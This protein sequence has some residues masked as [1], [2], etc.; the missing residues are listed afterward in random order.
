MGSPRYSTSFLIHISTDAWLT[1]LA[2]LRMKALLMPPPV[3]IS[4]SEDFLVRSILTLMYIYAFVRS[5]ILSECYVQATLPFL[6]LF[7]L[8]V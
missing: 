3:N 5:H 7:I 2:H 8:R 1:N 4:R 6:T